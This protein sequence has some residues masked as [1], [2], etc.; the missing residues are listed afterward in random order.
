M[1]CSIWGYSFKGG[2]VSSFEAGFD[3]KVTVF[4]AFSGKG[5]SWAQEFSCLFPHE[6]FPLLPNIMCLCLILM[7]TGSSL[8]EYPFLWSHYDVV[9]EEK[10]EAASGSTLRV[11]ISHLLNYITSAEYLTP[12]TV[13]SEPCSFVLP[14]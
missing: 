3:I 7:E 13:C 10:G 5:E 8:L 11:I 9:L 4:E 1:V 12:S 2:A 6:N 14:Q